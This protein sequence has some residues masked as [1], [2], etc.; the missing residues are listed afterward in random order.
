MRV[1]LQY[2]AGMN[3]V[4]PDWEK[5]QGIGDDGHPHLRSERARACTAGSARERPW[6]TRCHTDDGF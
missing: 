6:S 2:L 4:W 1:V 5:Q 3:S